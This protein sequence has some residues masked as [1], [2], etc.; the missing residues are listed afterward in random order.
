MTSQLIELELD[1][2]KLVVCFLLYQEYI[3]IVNLT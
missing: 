2:E 3:K 1:Q